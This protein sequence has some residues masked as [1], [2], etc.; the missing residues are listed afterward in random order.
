MTWDGKERRKI[1]PVDYEMLIRMDEKLTN[2]LKRQE[3]HDR[4]IQGNNGESGAK[5][6]IKILVDHK[7]NSEKHTFVAWGSFFGLIGKIVYDKLF[8]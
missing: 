8:K 3:E 6:N 2:A 7:K 4:F 5:A 1:I